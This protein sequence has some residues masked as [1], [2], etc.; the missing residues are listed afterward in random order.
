MQL[1]TAAPNPRLS[2]SRQRH[3]RALS[4]C[5]KAGHDCTLVSPRFQA[6]TSTRPAQGRGRRRQRAGAIAWMLRLLMPARV[7]IATGSPFPA[8]RIQRGERFA[9]LSG[10]CR[11]PQPRSRPARSGWRARAPTAS[12]S[13]SM[14]RAITTQQQ[15]QAG[16]ACLGMDV[17]AGQVN[18][19]HLPAPA[20]VH[21]QPT[22]ARDERGADRRRPVVNLRPRAHSTGRSSRYSGNPSARRIHRNLLLVRVW[23]CGGRTSGSSRLQVVTSISSG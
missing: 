18:Q 9:R 17:D 13:T 5:R 12:S 11:H 16:D 2:G 8:C 15:D 4:A 21:V 7:R 6:G 10:S 3:G 1:K 20:A 14:E 23:S 22:I 19:L